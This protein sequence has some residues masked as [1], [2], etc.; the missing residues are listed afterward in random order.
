MWD[1]LIK[2]TLLFDGRGEAPHICDV[3]VRDGLI[4]AIIDRDAA[5]Y[6][7]SESSAREVVDGR[8]RWLMPGLLDIHTHFDLEVELDPRL[9][10]AVRHGTTTVVMS[11]CSLG[12]A[13]GAQRENDQNPIVDCFARVENVPKSVLQK[14][15]D[16]VDWEDPAGYYRHLDQLP[17]GPNVVPMIPHSMLRIEAMGLKD[18]ISRNP[19]AAELRRM[20]ELLEDGMR[21]GYAGFSTD[22]L[23]FHYLANQP[24]TRR[25]IPGQYGSYR[26][27]RI[28]TDV[29]RRHDRVWQATPPKD[30]PLAVLRN[31]LLTSGRLFG[32]TLKITAVAAMDLVT[33][34]SIIQLVVLLTRL[35]NSKFLR[36]KFVLQAL[37]AAFKVW[38]EG[39]ITPLAEE[40]PVLREL[41]ETELEDRAGRKSVMESPGYRKRFR[42]MWYTGLKGFGLH[43]IKRWLGRE[44]IALTRRLKDM[45]VQSC[46]VAEWAGEDLQSVY[47]R[48]LADGGRSAA[49]REVF[50]ELRPLVKDDADF[51]FELLRKFDT[52]LYWHTVT[53][54]ANPEIVRELIMHPQLLPGFNDSGA[55]LTNMAFYDG[56]LR[57]LRLAREIGADRGDELAAV[58]RMVSRLT[59]EPAE[60]FGL[61]DVG[62]INIGAR[63]DLVLI[64]PDRL[65]RYDGEAGIEVRYREEFEYNQLVNRSD[66]VV[67]CV[68]IGGIMVWKDDEITPELGAVQAG[69]ALRAGAK[70]PSAAPIKV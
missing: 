53:A 57:S 4:A 5:D 20:T 25:K 3:A 68:I 66:G 35:L 63:A 22:A 17:L 51:I 24:N 46:P 38:G 30:N 34:R 49:E 2:N 36:G 56:N 27:L 41:N 9:P 70:A 44:D 58:A 61:T 60:L 42:K 62:S 37:P 40:I 28:L 50:A 32:S 29:V 31:F 47:E 6:D 16:R 21:V 52:D 15:V 69:R 19:T 39:A 33:N 18:S 64:D 45:V 7:E 26:E 10:E 8:G 14:V 48:M 23:P 59:R 55:H 1:V 11:N 65:A 13:F 12:L 43:R 54:N 67:P